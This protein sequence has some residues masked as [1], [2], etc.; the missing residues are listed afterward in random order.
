MLPSELTA[1][2]AFKTLPL[3]ICPLQKSVYQLGHDLTFMAVAA[4]L[5]LLTQYAIWR[6][7]MANCH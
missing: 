1:L 7:Y 2:Y 5:L 4:T 6:W 3:Y